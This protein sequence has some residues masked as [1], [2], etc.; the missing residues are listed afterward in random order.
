M[1]QDLRLPRIPEVS[2]E[3]KAAQKATAVP[4]RSLALSLLVKATAEAEAFLKAI[5][6]ANPEARATAKAQV[7]ADLEAIRQAAKKSRLL[8][9][10]VRLNPL[11]T[12]L[13][14]PDHSWQSPYTQFLPAGLNA[15]N[16]RI[17]IW[18]FKQ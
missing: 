17:T 2:P 1:N 8:P 4:N 15:P 18:H 7:K 9:W 6:K 11:R 12:R 3:L 14:R 5:R 13:A 10:A 16:R